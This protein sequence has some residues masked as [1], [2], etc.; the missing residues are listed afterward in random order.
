MIGFEW[1]MIPKDN[2]KREQPLDEFEVMKSFKSWVIW[3][4]VS[5]NM[6]TLLSLNWFCFNFCYHFVVESQLSF[7]SI[8]SQIVFIVSSVNGFCLSFLLRV[9]LSLKTIQSFCVKTSIGQYFYSYLKISAENIDC[10]TH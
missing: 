9:F 4:E 8:H 10:V 7:N 2:N 5:L 3:G 1:H 6:T